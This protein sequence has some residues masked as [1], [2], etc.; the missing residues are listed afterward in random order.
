MQVWNNENGS[1]L[2]RWNGASFYATMHGKWAV[3][4][5]F[6]DN[7]ESKELSTI[8]VLTPRQ[9]ANYRSDGNEYIRVNTGITYNWGWGTIG[10]IYDDL[11]WGSG[12]NGTNIFSG[13]SPSFAQ[14]KFNMKPFSWLELNYFHGWLYSMIIDSSR[15]YTFPTTINYSRRDVY[16]PKYVAAN[17]LTIRP[18]KNLLF[19]VGN[20][21]IYSDYNVQPAYL[22]P[23]MIF[24]IA[25]TD[26]ET[27]S[28]TAGNNSQFFLDLSVIP[29]RKI[30]IYSSLFIDEI[31]FRRMWNPKKQS[32]FISWKAG[33]KVFNPANSNLNF[34]FEYTRTNPEVYRHVIPTTS[35]TSN[36]FTLGHYLN[37]NAQEIFSSLE[38]KPINRLVAT[39]AYTGIKKGPNY[40]GTG[41]ASRWGLPF[42]E[43]VVFESTSVE[44]KLSYLIK[45]NI[46]AWLEFSDMNASGDMTMVPEVY[47]GR[48]N[49]FSIGLAWG[50]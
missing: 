24:R 35:F 39:L 19:S 5:T 21:I 4:S 17:M 22:I 8:N 26:L 10:L 20:S 30:Q 47:N 34:T 12:Y 29:I 40:E 16:R 33:I 14:L 31:S 6:R 28:N 11:S 32:N 42:M 49:T 46:T 48:T 50:R 15:S 41:T 9:G 43:Y 2:H 13:K 23:V 1:F 25:D 44:A 45:N 7:Y 18:F 36:D 3:Y 38:F 27:K 37:D